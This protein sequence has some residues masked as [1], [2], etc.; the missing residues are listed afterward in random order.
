MSPKGFC[1][2]FPWIVV[3]GRP[4]FGHTRSRGEEYVP[5]FTHLYPRRSATLTGASFGSITSPSAPSRWNCSFNTSSRFFTSISGRSGFS[6][7]CTTRSSSSG[8]GMC[9][10]RACAIIDFPVPGGPTSRKC[11]RC[12]AASRARSTASCWPMTRESGSAGIATSAVVST[13]LRANPSAALSNV[14]FAMA[15]PSRRREVGL[16]VHVNPLRLLRD[17]A[18]LHADHAPHPDLRC[19]VEDPL[20]DDA[21]EDDDAGLTVHLQ[22]LD[23]V[24]HRDLRR[25]AVV[26]VQDFRLGRTADLL[27]HVAILVELRVRGSAARGGRGLASGRQGLEGRV[28]ANHEAGS[29]A[30]FHAGLSP[31]LRHRGPR[32]RSR[33][34]IDPLRG[35][36]SLFLRLVHL[37]REA[38]HLHELLRGN[39]VP[40]GFH[41]LFLREFLDLAPPRRAG[42]EVHL[43]DL[44]ELAE[45]QIPAAVP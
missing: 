12:I 32:L 41:D 28:L 31:L 19:D 44:E 34:A 20:R 42:D 17:R 4:H 27:E 14:S 11:R 16:R 35:G 15:H 33:G 8:G 23:E 18:H 22:R 29:R 5:Q 26:L 13:S 40:Q 36:R 6:G 38:V 9:K 43:G 45:D 30:D 39:L 25:D 24:P 21:V 1:A 10:A 2:A 37:A 7:L 3:F